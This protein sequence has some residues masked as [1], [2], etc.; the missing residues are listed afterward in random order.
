MVEYGMSHVLYKGKGDSVELLMLTRMLT[1]LDIFSRSL[2]IWLML[3]IAHASPVPLSSRT[4]ACPPSTPCAKPVIVRS[5]ITSTMGAWLVHAS[6]LVISRWDSCRFVGHPMVRYRKR[7]GRSDTLVG[8]GWAAERQIIAELVPNLHAMH[9]LAD[10][11][12]VVKACL[13]EVRR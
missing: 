12:V 7:C 13:S 9:G 2:A 5:S 8:V 4:I 1:R 10:R 6:A 11:K 3:P